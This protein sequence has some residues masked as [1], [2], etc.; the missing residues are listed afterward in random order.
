MLPGGDFV[1]LFHVSEYSIVKLWQ[2]TTQAINEIATLSKE[3][4][5]LDT[6][7]KI[8]HGQNRIRLWY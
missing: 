1:C 8:T 3:V 6:P 5:I 4:E 7:M 2:I